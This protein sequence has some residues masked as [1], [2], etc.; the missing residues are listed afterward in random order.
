MSKLEAAAMGVYHLQ[1]WTEEEE[2][3]ALLLWRLGGK[4]TVKINY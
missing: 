3:R 4:R 2:M 1:G